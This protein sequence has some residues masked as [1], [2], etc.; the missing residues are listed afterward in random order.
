MADRPWVT[1][2]EVRNY[3]ESPKVKARS[4]ER[5]AIDITRAEQYVIAYTHNRFEDYE[6]LPDPVKAAV[7]ILADSHAYT[8]VMTSTT[9][10]MKSETF[11]DYSY[12]V[13]DSASGASIE[14]LG[15]NIL[16]DEFVI[17]D[18]ASGKITMRMRKL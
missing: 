16:L 14:D 11:D 15:L 7:I 1:P 8:A 4:D 18:G 12:T 17:D 10:G 9:G 3:S 2:D 6:E 13:A 5:L